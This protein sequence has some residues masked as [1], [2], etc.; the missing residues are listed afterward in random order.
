[1][2]SVNPPKPQMAS[3]NPPQIT[4]PAPPSI[5]G[6]AAPPSPVAQMLPSYQRKLVADQNELQRQQTTGSGVSQIKN[7][8]LRGLARVGD[9]AG[10]IVAPNI[11]AAVPGT[12]YHH[13]VLMGQQANRVAGDQTN[14]QDLAK[15]QQAAAQL[16]QTQASTTHTQAQTGDIGAKRQQEYAKLGLKETTN[17][18][19]TSAL[20]VDPDSPVTK[21]NADK[22][23]KLQIQAQ[24][25]SAQI[26][27]TKAQ[28]ELRDAQTAYNQAKTDPNSPL[29]KQT[30]QRLAIA[31][32]NA[33][34]AGERAKAYWG[35]YLQHSQNLGLDGQVLPGAPLISDDAGNQTA[36]GSTNA[37]QAV[38]GQSNAAR[39]N[40]VGGS[41]DA[42]DSALQALH[43]TGGH[44][45]SPAVLQA[46]QDNQTPVAQWIQSKAAQTLTPQERDAVVK[47]KNA[48]EQVMAL[49]ASVGGGVSDSQVNRLVSQVPDGT[50]P[51]YDYSKRQIDTLRQSIARLTPGV[52]TA[53]KGLTVHGDGKPN[54]MVPPTQKGPA[55]GTVKTNSSGDKIVF[56]GGKWGPA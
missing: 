41:L 26:E 33:N 48:R 43:K 14:I 37:A 55:E 35:N 45:N 56:R 36:V 54:N 1:M 50:S 51:D 27:N 47:V 12:T 3:A 10:S 30:S 53:N 31:Q 42:L 11:A 15:D 39:F 44:L 28:K 8:W 34:A 49:R 16:A 20:T 23:M 18:D 19:G 7:P 46:L 17:P 52:T 5:Y 21:A 38:K 22:D 6:S 9:I 4:P 25:L 24:L 13:D 2:A 29:F 32:Q 40:D